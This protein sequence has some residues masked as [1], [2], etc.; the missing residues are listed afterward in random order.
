MLRSALQ[1]RRRSASGTGIP[2][3][4]RGLAKTLRAGGMLQDPFFLYAHISS[5]HRPYMNDAQCNLLEAHADR[6]GNRHFLEQLQCVNRQLEEFLSPILASD[7]GAIIILSSDHGPRLSVRLGT[8]LH[9][10]SGRQVRESL[11]ILN[12]FRLP[13]RCQSA[14]RPDLTPV[15]T[16]RIVFACLGDDEPRLLPPKYFIVRPDSQQR[17]K[18]RRVS[19]REGR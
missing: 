8:P 18:L 16:M 10:L 3:L 6:R 19:L 13:A 14:L 15:N 1:P 17:G 5:P 11:G 2:E 9:A 4:A 7:P 12:A